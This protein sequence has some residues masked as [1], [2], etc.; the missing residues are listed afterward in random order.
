MGN[1]GSNEV[2]IEKDGDQ[3]IETAE[4]VQLSTSLV[5]KMSSN[6]MPNESGHNS[7]IKQEKEVSK[8]LEEYQSIIDEREKQLTD[9]SQKWKNDLEQEK[10]KHKTFCDQSYEEFQ[11][12]AHETESKFK[13]PTLK[14]VC[15]TLQQ[16]LI[17]CYKNNSKQ[18]LN[19]STA[20][21][22]FTQ[23]VNKAKSSLLCENSPDGA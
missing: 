4:G 14:P 1:S 21:K 15:E 7:K 3:F 9:L 8:L 22:D 10:E 16:Q 5:Q 2:T 17:D 20:L 23:C 12:S 13:K 19:C 11:R 6:K 18:V